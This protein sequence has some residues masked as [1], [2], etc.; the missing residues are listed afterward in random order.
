MVDQVVP[1]RLNPAQIERFVHAYR[2][3][4]LDLRDLNQHAR[5]EFM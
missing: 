2:K 3:P 5:V 4:A 1:E